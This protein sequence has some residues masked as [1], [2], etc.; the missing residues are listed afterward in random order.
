MFCETAMSMD[1][2]GCDQ[3][4]QTSQKSRRILH[5]GYQDFYEPAYWAAYR[6]IVKQ[7]LLG[8][9][10]SVEAACHTSDSGRVVNEPSGASFDPTPWG[11]SSPEH[12]LNWRLIAVA[13][14][15]SWANPGEHWY[16]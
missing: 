5:I 6:N 15:A 11:Y 13:Q 4:I 2:N 9:V 10:Y 1:V 14:T 12:L 7:G 8:E 16:L 3:M